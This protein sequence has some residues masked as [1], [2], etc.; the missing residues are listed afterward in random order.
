MNI[1]IYIVG[2]F[3]WGYCTTTVFDGM[4]EFR[5]TEITTSLLLTILCFG[6]LI[7]LL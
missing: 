2:L 4:W 5:K 1:L 7:S 6:Y 3:S